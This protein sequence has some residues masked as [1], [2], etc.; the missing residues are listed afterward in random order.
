MAVLWVTHDTEEA[1]AV[2]DRVTFLADGQIVQE[3]PTTEVF[4][5]PSSEVVA[6]YLGVDV[7]LE[8]DVVLC[9]DGSTRLRLASGHELICAE[10]EPG[11]AVACIHPEDVILF[12][13]PPQALETS[14]RNM[15]AT[16]VRSSRPSGRAVMV[17]L[18]WGDQRLEALIT[19]AALEEL[20]LSDGDAVYAAVKASAVQV[21]PRGGAGD[22]LMR[23]RRTL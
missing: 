6:E 3:G 12:R 7:W 22:H 15:L 5:N 4:N 2:A 17:T 18:D 8:G 21:L 10:A 14:L 1:L 13:A 20:S 23:S 11:P 16:T 19:R 9:D